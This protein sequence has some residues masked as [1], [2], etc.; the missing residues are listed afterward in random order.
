MVL[1]SSTNFRSKDHLDLLFSITELTE[2]VVESTDIDTFLQMAVELVADHLNVPVCSIYLYDD[3]SG[4][5]VLKATH[6][7]N[8]RAVN[9][10]SMPPG[11]GLVGASFKSREIICEGNAR[12]N[13]QYKYFEITDEAPFNSFLCLPV[14]Q[15]L[16]TIGVLVVQHYDCDYFTPSDQTAI[17]AVAAQL[18]NT[19]DN[20]SLLMAISQGRAPLEAPEPLTLV[21]GDCASPGV[22]LGQFEKPGQSKSKILEDSGT[23][24]VPIT[25]K[26]FKKVIEKTGQELKQLQSDFI[27]QLPEN[28]SLIFTSHLMILKDKNFSGKM[29]ELIDS[30][31]PP[32]DA[33][34]KVALKYISIFS[35]S[36]SPHLKEK[37]LDIEDLAVR[38]L[39]NFNT[40]MSHQVSDLKKNNQSTILVA[41]ELYPSDL[42]D[43]FGSGIQ[44]I[45]LT[46]GGVTSHVA[47]LAKSL[48]IPLI[49][50][51]DERLLSLPDKTT[52]LMDADQGNIFVNP[53]PDTIR[54]FTDQKA[55]TTQSDEIIIKK[56][57]KTKDGETVHLY[58]NINLLSEVAAAR[59]IGAEG[60]GLYRTEFPFLIRNTFPTE[61]EQYTIYKKLL[62]D[63][64]DN[65]PVT[66][67]TLDAGGEKKLTYTDGLQEL[68][69]DLGLRSIRFSFKHKKVFIDQIRAILRAACHHKAVRI[70]FPMISSI[71]DFISARRIVQQCKKQLSREQVKFNKH[72][73]T[74]MMVELPSV[75]A[76][77]EDFA[78]EV[79]FF[80]IGTNDF[81]QYMLAADRNNKMVADY[82]TPFHPAVTRAL[83][84]VTN[85]ACHYE[86]EISV[87]GEMIQD[88]YFL[89]FLIGI[90]IRRVSLSPNHLAP[91]QET[92]KAV[93]TSDARRFA[94][95]I[96]MQSTVKGAKS[97]M[98]HFQVGH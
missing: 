57:T 17:K 76:T 18:A 58:A 88:P 21:K 62:L 7:L 24:N 86:K 22:A 15:R 81:V 82:Y 70:M 56:E 43:I 26:E 28:A 68:N 49:I 23:S 38:I 93:H 64:G 10:V 34:R 75:V 45:I 98:D 8:S 67:R 73:A 74:G 52:L 90:G 14:Q 65:G 95:K 53:D 47:I 6:G 87:C 51:N 63:F 92:I 72:V 85:T 77:I 80:S 32:G 46:S 13:P 20:A 60:I 50:A 91:V 42:F 36:P 78:K 84:I 16:K 61:E 71:D 4:M 30:G 12:L 44:G 69:P 55:L 97:I 79:D 48:N 39:N 19:M 59:K 83:E 31:M 25:K 29:E 2:L 89:R 5:L 96:L 11:Q 9:L 3:A 40:D 54:L 94:D 27:T 33:V 37:R 41:K 35:A 66:I 1:N